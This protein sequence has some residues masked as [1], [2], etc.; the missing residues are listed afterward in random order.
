VNTNVKPT[1]KILFGFCNN[2]NNNTNTIPSD[3]DSKISKL[4]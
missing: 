2:K 1:I 4:K 3:I